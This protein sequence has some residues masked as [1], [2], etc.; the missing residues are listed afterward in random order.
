MSVSKPDRRRSSNSAG[1]CFSSH[2]VA[3][4]KP[5]R[6]ASANAWEG[7]ARLDEVHRV[8]Q[9]QLDTRDPG[10]FRPRRA[11]ARSEYEPVEKGRVRERFVG[12]RLPGSQAD[13]DRIHGHGN[14]LPQAGRESLRCN[15]RPELALVLQ[16]PRCVICFSIPGSAIPGPQRSSPNCPYEVRHKLRLHP[17]RQECR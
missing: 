10:T 4:A 16:G 2:T 12:V 14:T 9:Q 6:T 8:E 3:R 5:S 17:D 1:D 13:A 11:I 7:S 15:V